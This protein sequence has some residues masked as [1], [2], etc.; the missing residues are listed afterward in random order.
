MIDQ[1]RETDGRVL[2]VLLVEDNAS[3]VALTQEALTE[4]D[5]LT[6]L[7]VAADGAAALALLDGKCQPDLVL[8]DLNLPAGDG[9][10]VLDAIRRSPQARIRSLP[11]I[12]L[13]TSRASTDIQRAYDRGAS[14][15]VTKPLSIDEFFDAVRVLSDFWLR[16]AELP[17]PA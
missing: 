7:T 13:T 11:V 17:R 3:D 10:E 15:F 8:L 12:V 14:A 2:T 9:L 1:L 4:L 5:V 16:V 6:R